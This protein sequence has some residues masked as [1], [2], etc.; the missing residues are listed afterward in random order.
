MA[1]IAWLN[2]A[3]TNASDLNS[4][5]DYLA[6]RDVIT[7]EIAS[8]KQAKEQQLAR[9]EAERIQAAEAARAE[10]AR[11]KAEQ[12]ALA[13]AEEQEKQKAEADAALQAQIL[14]YKQAQIEEKAAKLKEQ[15]EAKAARDA[16]KAARIAEAEKHKSEHKGQLQSQEAQRR[17]EINAEV[18]RRKA[19]HLP[20]AAI[21][22]KNADTKV[23]KAQAA[24]TDLTEEA[25]LHPLMHESKSAPK[26]QPA[27]GEKPEFIKLP[28]IVPGTT[29]PAKEK[30]VTDTAKPKSGDEPP[31][32]AK[33]EKPNVSVGKTR[34]P[35]KIELSDE[36]LG[37]TANPPA[38]T[39]VKQIEWSKKPT[40]P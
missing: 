31:P 13:L 16:E 18:A 15:Q 24:K 22:A 36:E 23:R 26:I 30:T 6:K 3:A 7:A 33:S 21:K 25:Q 40:D 27:A 8:R 19:E 35:A 10:A 1:A 39:P 12:A 2:S 32:I 5:N 38:K 34:Y 20:K 37:H 11:I 14:A 28:K 9:E 29:L 4:R 17:A